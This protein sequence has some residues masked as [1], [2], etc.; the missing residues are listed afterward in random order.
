[1][2]HIPVPPNLNGREASILIDAIGWLID[3]L[4]DWQARLTHVY[5]HWLEPQDPDWP[6]D[7]EN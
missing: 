7:S 2:I 6:G 1:M 3:A 5:A 4:I